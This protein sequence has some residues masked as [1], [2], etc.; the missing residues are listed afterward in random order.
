MKV[1]ALEEP[2]VELHL[3]AEGTGRYVAY[4]FRKE[5][6]R[7][8]VGTVLGGHRTW[9]AEGTGRAVPFRGTSRV[10]VARVLGKWALAHTDR[11]LAT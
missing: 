7:V 1:V 4:L 9:S 11:F 3:D 10:A 6:G 8:R 5:T 2:G